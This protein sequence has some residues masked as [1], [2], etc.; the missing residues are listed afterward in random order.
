MGNTYDEIY[1]YTEPEIESAAFE[2]C[3]S[4][5]ENNEKE[6]FL[7]FE[8]RQAKVLTCFN[9]CDTGEA[10]FEN[11]SRE[12]CE[13]RDLLC[14][15]HDDECEHTLLEGEVF[16]YRPDDLTLSLSFSPF[17]ALMAIL[18]LLP[19]QFVFEIYCI[20]ITYLKSNRLIPFNLV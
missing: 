13:S 4:Y 9:F 14:A 3:V 1:K 11:D 18:I 12:N 5:T 20:A 17:H 19:L 7:E 8:D 6:E 16:F 15:S 2:K 10:G